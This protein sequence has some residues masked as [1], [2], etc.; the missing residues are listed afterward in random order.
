MS[1]ANNTQVSEDR[2]RAEI[3]KQLQR[4]GADAFGYYSNGTAAKIAFEYKRIHCQ[5]SVPLPARDDPQ[6]TQTPNTGRRRS[7]TQACT[8]WQRE[9]RRRWRSLCL[10]VKALLVGVED[11]VLTFEQAFMPYIVMGDGFT[12][13]QHVIPHIEHAL[14]TGEMPGTLKQLEA[15]PAKGAADG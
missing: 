12:I 9:V 15:L 2:S 8:D 10:V 3:E 5:I 7:E 14:A 4:F 13:Y 11:G 1:Y 6:F